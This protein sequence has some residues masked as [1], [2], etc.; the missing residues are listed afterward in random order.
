MVK[1]MEKAIAELTKLPEAQQESMAQWI[2][3]ELDDEARWDQ[4]FAHSLPLLEKLGQKALED[5]HAGRTQ[6]LNPDE[7]E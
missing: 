1:L 3:A 4:A 5:Y 7:L 2:L 6:D